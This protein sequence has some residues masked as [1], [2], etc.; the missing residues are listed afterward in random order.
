M[1][2]M[3]CSCGYH[4]E[5]ANDEELFEQARVHVDKCHEGLREHAS[6]LRRVAQGGVR[7]A[8]RARYYR[9]GR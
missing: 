5:A 3:A 4:L 6:T 2:A 8:R 1:R 7:L 9:R